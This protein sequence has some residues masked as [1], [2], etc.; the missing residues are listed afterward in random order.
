MSAANL[1]AGRAA[2]ARYDWDAGYSL[3]TAGEFK[4][5]LTATDLEGIGEAAFWTSR[6]RDCVRYREQS[7]A[8]YSQD[9]QLVGAARVALQLVWDYFVLR[10]YAVS[11]GWFA[12]AE[13]LLADQP[14][15][16]EHGVLANFRAHLEIGEGKLEAA[17][18]SARQA[19]AIGE[20]L[21]DADRE[22]M[23]LNTQG[24]GP[25]RLGQ[26]GG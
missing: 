12:K 19:Y 17:L 4:D 2:L 20:R 11:S 24:A 5:Q 1:T 8:A 9:V 22:A 15:C 6:P 16:R 7:F 25:I 10:R 23:S 26:V 3:L 21:G 14:E 13:R 18:A